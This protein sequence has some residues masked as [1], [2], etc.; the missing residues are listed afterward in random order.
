MSTLYVLR[1]EQNRYYVGKTNRPL[2][3]RI[4]E[5]FHQH[6]SEWTRQYKPVAVVEQIHNVDEFDEDKYTKM[7]MKKYGIDRV[8]GGSYTQI[9]LP[10]HYRLTLEKELCSASNRC[11]RCHRSGHFANNCYAAS[12]VDGSAIEDDTDD[13]SVLINAVQIAMQL[14]GP[15]KSRAT[16]ERRLSCFRCGRVG[17]LANKCY[18][19]THQNGYSF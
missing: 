17:H 3:Q 8:R 1:C 6:G 18:A 19:Q 5:H 11:F 9:V 16:T 14:L 13:V 2:L 4:A 12:K 7:Y 15:Q 10:E